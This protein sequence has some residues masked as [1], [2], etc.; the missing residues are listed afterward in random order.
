MDLLSILPSESSQLTSP[1][2]H[3]GPE[4]ILEVALEVVDGPDFITSNIPVCLVTEGILA[5]FF[6]PSRVYTR[7]DVSWF[8][9]FVNDPKQ[10]RLDSESVADRSQENWTSKPSLI[11][12]TLQAEVT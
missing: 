11:E 1:T 2:N 12:S 9:N 7:E 6:S 10:W 4:R 5:H 3:P 8:L